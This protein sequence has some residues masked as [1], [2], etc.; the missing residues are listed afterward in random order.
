MGPTQTVLI[1]AHRLSTIVDSDLILVMQEGRLVES[2]THDELM[3]LQARYFEL[4][5][6][7]ENA[8]ELSAIDSDR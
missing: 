3:G 5:R 4:Y 1:I 7:Q 2:G 8:R 6:A